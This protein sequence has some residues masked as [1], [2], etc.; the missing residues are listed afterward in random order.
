APGSGNQAKA[1]TAVAGAALVYPER[2]ARRAPPGANFKHIDSVKG[3]KAT[4]V[5]GLSIQHGKPRL[6]F[7]NNSASRLRRT[8]P[9]A[10]MNQHPKN[11][12]IKKCSIFSMN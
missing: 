11:S 4:D 10:T 5:S 3:A 1:Q 7:L 2:C 9:S 8:S 6:F 12:Q